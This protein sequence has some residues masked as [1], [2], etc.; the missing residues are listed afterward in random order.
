MKNEENNRKDQW[1]LKTG[2]LKRNTIAKPL[3]RLIKEK[4]E[5]SQINKFRKEGQVTPDTTQ[6]QRILRDYH[7][8][9][10]ANKMD[11]LEEM[12]NFLER[13]SLPRLNQEEIENMHRSITS[14]ETETVI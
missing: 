3:A 4:M 9:P 7:K 14:T 11:N 6:I 1:R 10:Y 12:D 8:Q 5:R 13:Y 2:S